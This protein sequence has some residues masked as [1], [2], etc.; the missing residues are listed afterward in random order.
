[1][2]TNT[3]FDK[4]DQLIVNKWLIFLL[5]ILYF[6]MVRSFCFKDKKAPYFCVKSNYSMFFIGFKG[7]GLAIMACSLGGCKG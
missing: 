3:L 2:Y 4:R 5:T 1:M 6:L 7:G